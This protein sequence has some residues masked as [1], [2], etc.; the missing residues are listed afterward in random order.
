[1]SENASAQSLPTISVIISTCDR[2]NELR[3]TLYSFHRQTYSAFEMIVVVGPT[4]DDTLAMLENEFGG[5][6]TVI[7][8][9]QF[10][11][12]ISRNKGLAQARGEICAFIDDDAIPANTWLEQIA[13]TFQQ[14][15]DVVAMGGR[16]NAS[17]PSQGF[18]QFHQG[19]ISP[20]GDDI[21]V[22][23]DVEN[24]APTKVHYPRV[25]GTNMAYRRD[26]LLEFGGFD[27]HFAYQWDEADMTLRLNLAGLRVINSPDVPVYHFPASGRNRE[28]FTWNFNWYTQLDGMIYVTLKQGS[29]MYGLPR[30]IYHSL[31]HYRR[32]IWQARDLYLNGAI[33]GELYAK[34]RRQINNALRDGFRAGLL[35]KR[36]LRHIKPA[37]GAVRPFQ[38][39]ES[40]QYPNV[41]PL[42]PRTTPVAPMKRSPL[43]I[44]LLSAN[45]LPESGGGI[46][47]QTHYMA[48][49]L[50]QLGHEVHVLKVGRRNHV[51]FYDGAYVHEIHAGDR[52]FQSLLADGFDM[53]SYILNYSMSVWERVRYLMKNHQIQ[54]VDSPLWQL[55][56]YATA[57]ANE[58]PVAVRLT[59]AL[60][61]IATINVQ[62]NKN[63]NLLAELETS[64]LRIA[65]GLSAISH[66]V[67][68]DLKK[69]YGVDFNSKCHHVIYAGIDPAP[70]ND[71]LYLDGKKPDEFVILYLG[72]LEKRK[73]I[74]D[75]FASV[76]KVVRNFPNARFWIVGEENSLHDGFLQ[77]TGMTY[78]QYFMR[79][80]P[81]YATHVEFIGY[82]P[83]E[84]MPKLLST[85]HMLI[86]PS[87]YESFGFIYVEAM[88]YGRPVIACNTGGPKE[89]VVDGETGF[90][91][92]PE[93][94]AQLAE[95]IMTMLSDPM[96]MRNMGIEG[97]KRVLDKFTYM[98]TARGCV[99]L[100]EMMIK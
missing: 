82:V 52:Y 42:P 1:M 27:E 8:I 11:L 66:S 78:Q 6:V 72:R 84:Y 23:E 88:N 19:A 54:V 30:A 85:A 25:M 18:E 46:A 90:L 77:E 24:Y 62:L 14:Y 39:K 97:R 67:S 44:C 94:P 7:S 51:T 55:D 29:K 13:R 2:C 50:S 38:D 10:N 69:V 100:Y 73:G 83:D 5:R 64:F 35:E 17:Y 63:N 93:A 87:L 60:K 98:H 45:Y 33:S 41:D 95:K 34:I 43:R 58:I 32:H 20:L 9:P 81:Q 16:V 57:V 74:L 91:I 89:V 26:V 92:D 40:P 15:P 36:K 86:A 99:E 75:V 21:F 71:V 4:Q 49:G 61:Q 47:R 37:V 68:K 65:Y 53:S 12:C 56:G 28:K 76:P 96:L 79:H 3:T 31:K 80:Y 59:T 70:E 48:R 22:I